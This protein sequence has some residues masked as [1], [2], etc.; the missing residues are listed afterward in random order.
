MP[1]LRIAQAQINPTVGDIDANLA[2]IY[3]QS[4]RARA[5]GAHLVTFPELAITGYPPEDLLIKPRFLDDSRAAVQE[6]A[7]RCQGINLVVGFA[8]ADPQRGQ[9][10]NAAAVISQG[11]VAAVYHKKELPNYGIF[12]E[13]RYFTPGAECLL[14]EMAGV[15]LMLTICEDVWVQGDE[16]EVCALQQKAQVVLNI[17]ASPFHAGKLDIRKNIMARFASATGT[18]VCYNNLFGSQDELVFD[19]GC[20]AISPQGETLACAPRFQPDLQLVDLEL[21]PAVELPDLDD[22]PRV[23]LVRLPLPC[24][25]PLRPAASFRAPAMGGLAEIYQAL[26]LGTRDY[27]GKNGFKRAVLGLSGGIDS[28]LT[29]CIA[30]AALGADNVTGVTMP[31][32]FTSGETLDDAG[33]LAAN[34]GIKLITVPVAHI[35]HIYLDELKEAFGPGPAGVEHENL[36]ARIRGN[37]L[38]AL[39]N[40]F[41][42]LVL[43]SGN[44]SETAVGYCTLYGDM[45]GGFA[46]I[47]DVPKT[48]VYELSAFVNQKAQRELIPVTTMERAPS[49]EL[50]PDQKDSDSLPPYEV[51]DPILK[52]YVENDLVLDEIVALGHDFATVREVIRL[53]DINE[54]KRRQAPPG[55]KITPKA[56]GR[57][58]RLPITNHY[59]P[60]FDRKP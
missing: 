43:T 39:S 25:E 37:I 32:Q 51:L 55:I 20:L 60:G 33:R 19:G 26:V 44:K 22:A 54:Y 8:D 53:V 28:A 9:C 4:Q 1:I 34:L 31:S 23:K 21:P 49:A 14:L 2:L 52:A 38:M 58:R 16:C 5:A 30:V 10:Y 56:F 15:R 29:A 18:Y 50:R 17:S 11:Q 41:G 42:W 36:Q 13:K 57:D 46:V 12:D 45:A 59:R 3:E 24:P 6:L 48:L 35:Y 7:Q 40:R 47:K 27:M